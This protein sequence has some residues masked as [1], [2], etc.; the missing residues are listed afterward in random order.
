MC[1]NST[2]LGPYIGVCWTDVAAASTCKDA[3]AGI[4]TERDICQNQAGPIERASADCIVW[5]EA[6]DVA[7]PIFTSCIPPN[8]VAQV[9]TAT[10]VGW[11]VK[12]CALSVAASLV[13]KR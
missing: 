7:N 5:I 9:A 2:G 8:I 4:N 11:L 13:A 12:V 6:L 3:A 10:T 1:T